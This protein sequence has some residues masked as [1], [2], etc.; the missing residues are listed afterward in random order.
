MKNNYIGFSLIIFCYLGFINGFTTSIPPNGELCV[1]ARTQLDDYIDFSYQSLDES[2]I[3]TI[4]DPKGNILVAADPL[5]EI[6]EEWDEGEDEDFPWE[7]DYPDEPPAPQEQKEEKFAPPKYLDEEELPD[8]A[9]RHPLKRPN[10][11]GRRRLL[12]FPEAFDGRYTLD[13]E[14]VGVHKFCFQNPHETSLS[15]HFELSFGNRE[16]EQ[17]P[18]YLKEEHLTSTERMVLELSES[19]YVIQHEQQYIKNRDMVHRDTVDSTMKRVWW[20]T[21]GELFCLI[22]M[23]VYQIYSVRSFFEVKRRV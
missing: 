19:L 6:P 23:S 16:E 14:E 9:E 7:D 2:T 4:T 12:Q 5:D 21:S 8:P 18:N 11:P 15:I 1:G 13:A 10:T 3:L 22:A 20:Y 17:I